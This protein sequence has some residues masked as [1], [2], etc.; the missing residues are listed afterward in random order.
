MVESGGHA[1]STRLPDLPSAY[2]YPEYTVDI[3]VTPIF[4]PSKLVMHNT[5][6]TAN[7]KPTTTMPAMPTNKNQ[8]GRYEDVTQ[9]AQL[10]SVSKTILLQAV[11]LVEN[12]LTSDDQLTV[13]SK[14]LPGSTIGTY[15]PISR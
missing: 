15:N 14:F 8:I 11:D 7:A 4:P 2:T 6:E 5:V 1:R 13:H 3:D 12:H 9:L 10:V